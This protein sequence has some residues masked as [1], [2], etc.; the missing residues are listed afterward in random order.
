ML[1]NTTVFIN[2]T[3]NHTITGFSS[4]I[5][6]TQ[7]MRFSDITNASD[8]IKFYGAC[9]SVYPYIFIPVAV[10]SFAIGYFIFDTVSK[11]DTWLEK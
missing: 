10:L 1:N 11:K 9:I 4:V 7:Y 3:L 5:P 2:Q 6:T 8:V